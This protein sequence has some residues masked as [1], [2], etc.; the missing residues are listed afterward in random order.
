[1]PTVPTPGSALALTHTRTMIS[2]FV[3]QGQWDLSHLFIATVCCNAA[4]GRTL[5]SLYVLYILLLCNHA[6]N[7][8]HLVLMVDKYSR[9]K[10]L[11]LLCTSRCSASSPYVCTY[12][13]SLM[14]KDFL[15]SARLSL[16]ALLKIWSGDA[17]LASLAHFVMVVAGGLDGSKHVYEFTSLNKKY[18]LSSMRRMRLLIL[19]GADNFCSVKLVS[20]GREPYRLFECELKRSSFPPLHIFPNLLTSS[21][22]LFFLTCLCAAQS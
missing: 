1:M 18:V 14:S 15:S 3:M 21:C 19:A 12:A 20:R 16:Q 6:Y 8:R 7:A 13:C 2:V 5:G 17:R 4:D 11:A 10:A 9:T 22:D